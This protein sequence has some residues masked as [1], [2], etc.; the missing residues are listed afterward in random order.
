MGCE[1]SERAEAPQAQEAR[2]RAGL[3][4]ETAGHRAPHS[5]NQ[6]PTQLLQPSTFD[7]LDQPVGP[8]PAPLSC[9]HHAVRKLPVGQ[10]GVTGFD[11][12]SKFEKKVAGSVVSSPAAMDQL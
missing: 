8:S 4:C 11:A 6:R 5:K 12:D 3:R 2:A 1:V 9:H 10:S 7:G